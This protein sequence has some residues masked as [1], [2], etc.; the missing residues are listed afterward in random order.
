VKDW[1]GF[2]GWDWGSF[3]EARRVGITELSTQDFSR[4]TNSLLAFFIHSFVTRLGYYPSPLL[5]PPVLSTHN[6][7]DHRKK[8]GDGGI[9]FPIPIQ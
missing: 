3:S 8:F 6:C 4:F 9:I 7:V 1:D 5:R 2:D